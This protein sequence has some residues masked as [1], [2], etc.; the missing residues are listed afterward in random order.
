MTKPFEHSIDTPRGTISVQETSDPDFPG[1]YVSV[2]GVALVLVEFDSINDGH[3]VRVW[4]HTD[5]DNDYEYLQR[6]P[7]DFPKEE[8]E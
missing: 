3:A 8:E 4:P 2:N 5:P 7:N 6:L 1:Y